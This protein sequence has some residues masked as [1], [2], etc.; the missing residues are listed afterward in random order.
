MSNEIRD[1]YN[2]YHQDIYHYVSYLHR[3]N[4]VEDIVQEV[5]IQ[6]IARQNQFLGKSSVKTWLFAI[7]RNIA[8]DEWRKRERRK[9]ILNLFK[10]DLVNEN[11]SFEN[12]LELD[13]QQKQL[14]KWIEKLPL[15]Y[16]EIVILRGIKD[17]TIQECA[18]IL[19]WSEAKVT[20][21]YHRAIKK[22]QQIKEGEKNAE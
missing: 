2:D 9:R 18:A 21:T 11:K 19:D 17:L 7:A 3:S 16:K 10:K 13:E 1:W 6:A 8:I 5:F 15:S 14:V 20:L 22:L 12:K 4:D